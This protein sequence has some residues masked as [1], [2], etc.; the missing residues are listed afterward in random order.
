VLDPRDPAQLYA[1]V[2]DP[3][4]QAPA[5]LIGAGIY[6]S[7]DSGET[8]T[9]LSDKA[10][11]LPAGALHVD[12]AAPGA[13]L[14]GSRFKGVQ[15]SDD[16]GAAWRDSSTAMSLVVLGITIDPA[17]P[18]TVYACTVSSG[19][20]KS[21]DGGS[22]W[23]HSGLESDVVFHIAADPHHPGRVFA[24]TGRGPARSDDGGA[25]WTV[26]GQN[27]AQQGGPRPL[28]MVPHV[29]RPHPTIPDLIFAGTS[30]QGVAISEDGGATWRF[31][32]R[33][34][35]SGH[36]FALEIDPLDTDRL[37]ATTSDA[38]V[39]VSDD[40]GASWAPLNTGLYNEFVTSFAIDPLDPSV[41]YAGTEG[42]G[43]FRY[44]RP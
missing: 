3:P 34:L 12:R 17:N 25:T 21:T 20:F 39:W 27:A 30:A 23:R 7:L 28:A 38:G 8:W 42:G 35:G 22:T 29:I 5:A 18:E 26:V 14:A 6:R 1:V 43:V 32:N 15:R 2:E 36:I 37:Y 40:R 4:W 44:R 41:V 24:G 10:N 16:A 9:R 19:V 13:I 31:S 33:G 11:F